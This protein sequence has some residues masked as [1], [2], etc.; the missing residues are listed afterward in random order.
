[1]DNRVK[2]ALYKYRYI[3]ILLVVI[4]ALT[5]A[6]PRFL[7]VNNFINILW[8]VSIVGIISM[9]ASFVILVGKIDLS[10]GQTA[11][12]SGIVAALF[13]KSGHALMISFL[14]AIGV[15]IIVGVING[16]LVTHFQIPEFITTLATGSI[17]TGIAQIMSE[18]RT[19]SV[20]ESR[21]YIFIGSGKVAGIPIPVFCFGAAFVLAHIILSQTVYGRKCYLVGGNPRAS[22]ISNISVKRVIIIAYILSGVSAAF[23]GYVLSALN[24]QANATTASGYELDVIAAI[25]IG[26]A[27]MTGGVGT[28]PGT[29]FGVILIGLINNGLNLLSVPG[30]W[31]TVVKGIIIIV[32]VAFNNYSIRFMKLSKREQKEKG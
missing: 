3:I 9:G 4:L 32:A 10:V 19:I 7:S 6:T 26:G 24:Q 13:L 5:I 14:A 30:T 21:N 31:H 20:M 29:V 25:V 16:M 2:L 11:A 17:I 22:H 23:G 1:M 27:S 12:L 18:G 28:I 8:A 15:G